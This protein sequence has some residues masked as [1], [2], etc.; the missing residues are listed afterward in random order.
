[1]T[2]SCVVTGAAKGL[3]REIAALLV[4][5]DWAV[6]GVDVDAA[7]GPSARVAGGAGSTRSIPAGRP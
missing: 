4:G 6:V 2:R 5:R 1:M 7:G 3:G